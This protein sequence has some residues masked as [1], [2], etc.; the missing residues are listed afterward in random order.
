MK[1]ACLGLLVATILGGCVTSPV[2]PSAARVKLECSGSRLVRVESLW[3]ECGAGCVGVA[4][5]VANR[6]PYVNTTSTPLVVTL[7]DDEG[8][9]LRRFEGR[10][11]AYS[12]RHRMNMRSRYYV[13]VDSLP[14]A[15]ARLKVQALYTT[16][17]FLAD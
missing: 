8:H 11:E 17:Q 14:R 10:C 3:W 7:F 12:C 6:V 16:T 4:G 9:V 2:P 15:T 13:R 1:A 5:W